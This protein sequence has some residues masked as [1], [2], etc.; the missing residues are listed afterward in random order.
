MNDLASSAGAP[1]SSP[2]TVSPTQSVSPTS[3]TSPHPET[4]QR[5]S[6]S[7]DDA[8]AHERGQAP[9]PAVTL[10]PSLAHIVEGM[11]IEGAMV[12]GEPDGQPV[13]RT[14]AGTFVVTGERAIPINVSPGITW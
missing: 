6:P 1:S 13:L 2:T 8:S 11:R 5:Q 4:Q 10:A 14:D 3:S 7:S 9:A 12:A